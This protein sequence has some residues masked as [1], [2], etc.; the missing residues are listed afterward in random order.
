MSFIFILNRLDALINRVERLTTAVAKAAGISIEVTPPTVEI[1]P[2][3]PSLVISQSQL[4]NRYKIFAV[5]LAVA[6]TNQ[7]LGVNELLKGVGA[8]YASYMSIITVPAAF[9][10]KLNSTDMDAIDAALGLEWDGFEIT[11]MFITN[12]AL[13]GTA[14]IN[15]E[16]RVD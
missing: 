7:P 16:Y 3:P 15:V 14:L 12:V 13:V 1:T 6:R 9:T 10:F 2:L 8:T 4:P 5:D 11:E